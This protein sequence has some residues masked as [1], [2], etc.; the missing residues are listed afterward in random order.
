MTLLLQLLVQI[1]QGVPHP[2]DSDPLLLQTPFDYIFYI[3]LPILILIGGY[4][5]WRR[6]KKR[7]AEDEDL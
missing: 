6:K 4:F 7:E 1:P 5:W 2:D 3:G